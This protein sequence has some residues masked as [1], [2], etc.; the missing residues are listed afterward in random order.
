MVF[1]PT[2]DPRSDAFFDRRLG[3]ISL[4]LLM[5]F[6]D[7]SDSD[8]IPLLASFSRNSFEGHYPFSI[9]L[10]GM[11]AP[12]WL[13][14]FSRRG[15]SLNYDY[16]WAFSS[17]WDTFWLKISWVLELIFLIIRSVCS[18]IA[19]NIDVFIRSAS[20]FSKAVLSLSFYSRTCPIVF[21]S[22]SWSKT[23]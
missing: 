9:G 21:V 2:K 13:F 23:F 17:N 11:S 16:Y 7:C 6:S 8:S 4:I 5:A 20:S 18:C 3:P 1:S 14:W 22:W 12:K 15:D 10:I 19:S